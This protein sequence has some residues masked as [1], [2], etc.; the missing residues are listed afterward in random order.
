MIDY[1]LNLNVKWK[2]NIY[3]QGLYD[4][5]LICNKL[6]NNKQKEGCCM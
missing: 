2:R 5:E 1:V 6:L 4:K 3:S